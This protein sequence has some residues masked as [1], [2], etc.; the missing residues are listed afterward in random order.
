MEACEQLWGRR[1]GG[2]GHKLAS[3]VRSVGSLWESEKAYGGLKQA[4]VGRG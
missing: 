1:A 2:G 4:K 3:A